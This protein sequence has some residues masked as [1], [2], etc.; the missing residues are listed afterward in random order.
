MTID[1]LKQELLWAREDE[2]NPDKKFSKGRLLL[3]IDYII[4][5]LDEEKNGRSVEP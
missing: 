5:Y 4:C 1:D 2:A 3:L